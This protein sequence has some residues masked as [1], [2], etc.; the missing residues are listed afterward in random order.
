MDRVLEWARAHE[1]EIVEFIRTLVECESPSDSSADLDRFR[2]L[3][4]ES[5]KN[6]AGC[7]ASGTHLL[8]TFRGGG[9]SQVLV[10]GHHDTVWPLGTLRTMA[11]RESDGRLWDRA[12]SI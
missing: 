10:L 12:C 3:F 9:D 8:C 11:F 6:E 4:A 1:R 7:E 2:D 5:C